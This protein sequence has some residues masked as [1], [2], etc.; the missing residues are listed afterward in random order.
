MRSHLFV[1]TFSLL[2]FLTSPQFLIGQTDS[3]FGNQLFYGE[4]NE[5]EMRTSVMIL[6]LGESSSGIPII[7]D[8]EVNQVLLTG[9]DLSQMGTGLGLNASLIRHTSSGAF[10]FRSSTATFD[11][12]RVFESAAG[13]LE[14]IFNPNGCDRLITIGEPGESF[15]SDGD[16]LIYFSLELNRYQPTT[17]FANLFSGLR[18]VSIK[19]DIN[20]KTE[21]DVAGGNVAGTTDQVEVHNLMFGGQ[22]GGDFELTI[23]R[24]LRI[25]C[26]IRT[27][28]FANPTSDTRNHA[29]TL[30]PGQ[31][32]SVTTRQTSLA[33]LGEAT[34]KVVW[35]VFPGALEVEVGYQAIWFDGIALSY[36]QVLHDQSGLARETTHMHGLNIGVVLKR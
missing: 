23:A 26:Q 12:M 28:M 18:F 20:V 16:K 8:N 5:W 21:T 36:G 22:V 35:V 7:V 4:N 1:F 2:V 17:T 13:T 27:G 31:F 34:G 33:F 11:R 32:T 15:D 29:D 14:T 24:G 9:G 19:D 3:F 30:N 10:E 25:A 6:E